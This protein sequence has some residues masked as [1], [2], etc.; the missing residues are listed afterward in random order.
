MTIAYIC[1]PI[2]GDVTGN[3]EKIKDIM[4]NI[5]RHEPDVMPFA[6]YL[7][8]LEILDDAEPKERALGMAW[9]RQLIAAGFI[10]ELRLYGDRVSD[11]MRQEVEWGLSVMGSES[12][13]IRGMTSATR[14][15]VNNY[16]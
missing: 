5:V 12:P 9:N 2:S 1:H 13:V 6:P 8:A 7:T 4:R 3:V 15:W 10:H 14:L 16:E 11:G